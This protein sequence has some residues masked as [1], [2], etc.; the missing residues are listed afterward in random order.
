[1]KKALALT[2]VLLLLTVS[3]FACAASE[4]NE[5]TDVQ[6]TEN[7]LYGDREALKGVRVNIESAYRYKLLWDTDFFPES[8]SVQTDFSLHEFLEINADADDYSI[9]ISTN[10]N[11]L[12]SEDH[13]PLA[14]IFREMEEKQQRVKYVQLKDYSDYYPLKIN[15]EAKDP[16]SQNGTRYIY[17]DSMAAAASND[18]LDAITDFFKIPV[19]SD[20]ELRLYVIHD[21]YGNV[22]RTVDDSAAADNFRF[23]SLCAAG[24][25]GCFFTFNAH[26]PSGA[27]VDTSEIPGGFGI[28]YISFSI[29]DETGT[30]KSLS[31]VCPLDPEIIPIVLSINSDKTQ[32][33]LISLENSLAVLT[34]I[35]AKTMEIIQRTEFPELGEAPV[36][37]DYFVYD[38]FIVFWTRNDD[39]LLAAQ[40]G[41]GLFETEIFCPAYAE[42]MPEQVFDYKNTVMDYNG[43]RLVITHSPTGATDMYNYDRCGV[44]ITIF[45]KTGPIYQGIYTSSLDVANAF[46][47]APRS[48]SAGYYPPTPSFYETE[49]AP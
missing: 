47:N 33:R 46:E 38:D 24:R 31:N 2:L 44:S 40:N 37:W 6:Y 23:D 27:V 17:S 28:Y 25:D 36:F 3:A 30:L 7:V 18:L 15:L 16:A 43:E 21:N 29:D 19:L 4:L 20:E 9:V 42:G 48:C 13:M 39:L 5:G 22:S 8:N 34:V 49:G 35:D 11:R 14:K 1:M 26:H 41:S 32:L 45:D 12:F 10:Y